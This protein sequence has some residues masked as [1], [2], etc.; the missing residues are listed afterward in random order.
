MNLV[1][2]VKN[3][4]LTPKTEWGVIAAEST[5]QKDIFLGYVLP[6]AAFAAVMGFLSSYVVGMMI[7]SFFHM[8]IMW[9]LVGAIYRFV[10]TFVT[11][12]VVAFIVDALA[13]SFGGTKNMVQATKVVAYSFTAAWVG[14]VFSIIPFLGWLLSLLCALYCLYLLYLGL[15]PTMKNPEDKTIGYAAVVVIISIV[16]SIVI[17]A[18]GGMMTAGG[19]VGAGMMRGGLGAT[20]PYS[21]NAVTVNPKLEAYSK[22]LEE[23]SKQM[24]AAQKSGDPNKQMA[25]AMGALG[26]AMGGKGGVEP[27]QIDALKPFVPETFAGLPRKDMRTERGGV[28]GLMTAKAEGVYNDGA[29][30]H[31]SLEVIDTGGASGF[32]AI[33]GW[34]NLQSER[35]DDY[36]RESTHKDGNRMVHESVNK[37][38]GSNEYTVVL[39]ERFIVTAKGNADFDALR[40]SVA[41]LD[42]GKL[43][44]LK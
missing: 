17:A 32:M 28:Q 43:E 39:G 40:S 8:S 14:S 33:A 35:E 38:G 18:I 20:S 9:A 15:P 24:E 21:S 37:K 7:S 16:V 13:P 29:G 19:I 41:S 1:D 31:A 11:V 2:R 6:L 3:V 4:L 22:H 5:T 25:A 23:A 12:L 34:A 42:L 30:K 26:A 27:V 36:H 10:M 44:S